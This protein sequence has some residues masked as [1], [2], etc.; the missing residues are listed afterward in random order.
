M[1]QWFI[2]ASPCSHSH[3]V[4]WN[5]SIVTLPPPSRCV[6]RRVT[7]RDSVAPLTVD[8]WLPPLE[9]ESVPVQALHG[10]DATEQL[11][12]VLCSWYK[13]C[14]KGCSFCEPE[15]EKH[16]KSWAYHPPLIIRQYCTHYHITW[17]PTFSAMSSG[18]KCFLHPSNANYMKF[19]VHWC[20]VATFFFSRVYSSFCY[21]QENGDN[22]KKREVTMESKPSKLDEQKCI[23]TSVHIHVSLTVITVANEISPPPVTKV[24]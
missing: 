19:F 24:D 12:L 4:P 7:K 9:H 11:V 17:T 1:C 20:S 21:K 22:E 18:K 6:R 14:G 8:S 10:W 16:W 15:K 2:L 5:K 13:L 23:N 3:C